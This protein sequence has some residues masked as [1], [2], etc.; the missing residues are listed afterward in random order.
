MK[1]PS[2]ITNVLIFQCSAISL[3]STGAIACG[4]EDGKTPKKV[5]SRD[6]SAVELKDAGTDARVD[7]MDAGVSLLDAAAAAYVSL[8]DMNN[9]RRYDAAIDPLKSH[10]PATIEC[11]P[12]ATYVEY[13]AFEVDTTRCNYLLS[14]TPAL[15]PVPVGTVL[16]LNILHY[17][18]LAPEP[19]QTHIAVLFNDALQWEDTIPI[20]APGDSVET[21]FTSTVP[22]DFQDPI[23]LHLH[24]HGANTYLFVALEVPD[25]P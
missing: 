14:Y 21:T 12:S 19:A 17:D 16:R 22:L 2:G 10:Q 1:M 6:A 25:M 11:V 13:D 24:N 7:V 9:W 20:P 18:L 4:A 15:R 5:L 3:L 8:V 23:R